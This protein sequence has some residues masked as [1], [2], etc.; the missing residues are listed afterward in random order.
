[1]WFGTA[2]LY[3]ATQQQYSLPLFTSWHS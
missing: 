3:S 1:L 2:G